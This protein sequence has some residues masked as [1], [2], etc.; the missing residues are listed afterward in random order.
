MTN[1]E[2]RTKTIYL[3]IMVNDSFYCQ[4]P[5]E[6]CP[7]FPLEEDEVRKFVLEKRPLLKNKKFVINFSNNRV[8]K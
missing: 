3:D 6:Y 8:T 4:I 7:L 1:K 5:M 2:K